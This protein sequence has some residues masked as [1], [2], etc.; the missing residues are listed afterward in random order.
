[1]K[2]FKKIFFL[3]FALLFGVFLSP[4]SFAVAPDFSTLTDAVDY[5]TAITAILTV[6]AALAGVYIVM[7][8]GSLIL[9]KIRGGR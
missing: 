1:M 8:G 5:S 7:A 4:A 6:F 9:S 3:S 2:S